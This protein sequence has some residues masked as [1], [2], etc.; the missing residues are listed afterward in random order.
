MPFGHIRSG[1]VAA[2]A[3]MFGIVQLL[4]ACVDV[5]D[6]SALTPQ[7]HT[8]HQMS[9]TGQDHH[10]VLNIAERSVPAHDHGEHDHGHAADCS[11]C[12]EIVVLAVN[13]DIAPSIFTTPAVYKVAYF[14]RAPDTRAD[15]AATNLAGLRWLDP[16]RRLSS[17]DPVTLHTRSLI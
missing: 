12:D 2:F 10:G 14:D 8:S 16:P 15:M 5:P 6:R 3:V 13:V 1:L 9:T 17:T 11:H 7:S 4:C